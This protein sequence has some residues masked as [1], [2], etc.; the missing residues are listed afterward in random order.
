MARTKTEIEADIDN[1]IEM[2]FKEFFEDYALEEIIKNFQTINENQTKIKQALEGTVAVVASTHSFKIENTIGNDKTE[3]YFE[4][5]GLTPRIRV[6]ETKT[7]VV[8]TNTINI[9][10]LTA[11]SNPTGG[12]LD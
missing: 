2:K 6:V 9:L 8:S 10:D 4:F 11:P 3:T 7:G 1:K 12:S 5:D